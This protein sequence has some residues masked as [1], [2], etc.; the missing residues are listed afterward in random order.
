MV[1]LTLY[2]VRY[3]KLIEERFAVIKKEKCGNDCA[4]Y[5]AWAG[6]RELLV[7]VMMGLLEEAALYE[8][9]V[10]RHSPKMRRL[11]RELR[12]TPLFADETEKLRRFLRTNKRLHIE[13]YV[14]FRMGKYRE[15]LDMLSYRLIKKLNLHAMWDW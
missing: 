2:T 6:E 9:P 14:A 15:A 8:N 11:T 10:Y 7:Q 3:I 5:F 4:L 12:N 1:R 13:G